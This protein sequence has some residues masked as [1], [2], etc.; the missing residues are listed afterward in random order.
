MRNEFYWPHQVGHLSMKLKRKKFR[1]LVN[2]GQNSITYFDAI[3]PSRSI[4]IYR[5]QKELSRIGHSAQC[6]QRSCEFALIR[7]NDI[8]HL[9]HGNWV[10][11][12]CNY[13]FLMKRN[14]SK[15]GMSSSW[16]LWQRYF[17][18]LVLTKN[19]YLW[20]Y[21]HCPDV[22]WIDDERRGVPYSQ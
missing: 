6:W 18:T 17:L 11:Q 4:I 5:L 10:M 13:W 22:V 3:F 2:Y 16:T 15:K 7:G 21:F 20:L 12:T 1:P 9:Y 8:R 19:N 14:H